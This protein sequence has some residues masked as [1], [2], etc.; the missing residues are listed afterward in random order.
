MVAA[1]QLMLAELTELRRLAAPPALTLRPAIGAEVTILTGF[2]RAAQSI[3][4]GRRAAEAAL[5][6]LRGLAARDAGW[7]A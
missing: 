5:D 1:A 7:R 4:A 3:V 6:E 2:D